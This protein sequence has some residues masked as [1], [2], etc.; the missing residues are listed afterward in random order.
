MNAAIQIERT[1]ETLGAIAPRVV[2]RI[3]FTFEDSGFDV[4]LTAALLTPGNGRLPRSDIRIPTSGV[5]FTSKISP[6]ECIFT[7]KVAAVN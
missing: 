5:T 4:P 2:R 3:D 1:A 6:T 7:R